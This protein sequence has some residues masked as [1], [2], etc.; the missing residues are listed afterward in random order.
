MNYDTPLDWKSEVW[1]RKRSVDERLFHCHIPPRVSD[2]IDWT[3]APDPDWVPGTNLL[4]QGGSHLDRS[5]YAAE[6][7]RSAVT[8][9]ELSGKWVG[10]DDYI[11]MLKD[12]F[13][14]EGDGLPEMYSSPHLVKYIKGPFDVVV[15]SGLGDERLT[16]FAV[17]E[18]TGLVR[19]RFDQ[20]KSTIITSRL[21][22]GDIK[23]RYDRMAEVLAE[24]DL[25]V[26]DRR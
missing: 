22:M 7:L 2:L 20:M 12:S 15:I 18:L 10:A 16:D 26:C 24:F 4:I 1:W 17:H 6:L 23:N 3:E 11:E 21:R 19:R 14:T 5:V 25:E 8:Y 13:A 9:H